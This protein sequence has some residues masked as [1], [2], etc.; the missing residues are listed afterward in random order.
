ME[1]RYTLNQIARI[2]EQNKWYLLQTE[3]AVRR[4][5]KNGYGTV[6]VRYDLRAGEVEKMSVIGT[7]E[8]IL[9]PKEGHP[10]QQANNSLDMLTFEIFGAKL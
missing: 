7:E 3:D 6:T 10:L 9:R 1:E 2:M 4:F 8:T 5:L